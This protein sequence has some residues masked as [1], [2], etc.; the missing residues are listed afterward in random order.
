VSSIKKK[1]NTEFLVNSIV[2]PISKSLATPLSD[3][4]LEDEA[5]MGVINLTHMATKSLD[6]SDELRGRKGWKR[7]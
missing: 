5:A 2:V 7:K 6:C 3:Y 1:K 4:N